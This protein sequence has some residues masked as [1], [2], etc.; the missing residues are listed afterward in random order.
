MLVVAAVAY[1]KLSLQV[2][3]VF[4]V[5]SPMFHAGDR[6]ASFGGERMRALLH[7]VDAAVQQGKFQRPPI[8]PIGLGLSL[9]D[10]TWAVAVEVRPLSLFVS[11][12]T[13]LHPRNHLTRRLDLEL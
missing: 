7:R 11:C 1:S 10:D 6:L 12:A 4:K 3:R 2:Q 5:E 13:L 9:T 8:G